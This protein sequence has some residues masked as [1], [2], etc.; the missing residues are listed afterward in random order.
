MDVSVKETASA[1]WM[2][3]AGFVKEVKGA[4][5]PQALLKGSGEPPPTASSGLDWKLGRYRNGFS[6]GLAEA[7]LPVVLCRDAAHAGGA[8]G[9]RSKQDRPQ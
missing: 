6:V 5:E 4:S 2:T 1:L 3:R 9:A 8:E 7:G